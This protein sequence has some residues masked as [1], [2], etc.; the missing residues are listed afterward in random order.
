MMG[1][2]EWGGRVSGLVYMAFIIQNICQELG[3]VQPRPKLNNTTHC[4]GG[5]GIN[6]FYSPFL[7]SRHNIQ[8]KNKRKFVVLL[9]VQLQT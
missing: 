1:K 7:Y 8:G 4:T 3:C 5:T 6:T 2:H 9:R